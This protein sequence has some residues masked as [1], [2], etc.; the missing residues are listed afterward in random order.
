M[1]DEDRVVAGEDQRGTILI[2]QGRDAYA[3]FYN[4]IANP[5]LW[6]VQH[7][8]WDLARTPDWDDARH[9][10]WTNGYVPV[11]V[12]MARAALRASRRTPHGLTTPKYYDGL[13]R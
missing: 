6:F 3:R 8:L 2:A 11:N 13:W 5:T 12:R 1:T 7:M 4:V 10:A 9:D